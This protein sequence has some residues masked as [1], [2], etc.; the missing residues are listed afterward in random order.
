MKAFVIAL[1]LLVG[2]SA[3][4]KI[5]LDNVDMSSATVNTNATSNVRL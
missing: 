4:A 1:V 3:I 5:A 2:I